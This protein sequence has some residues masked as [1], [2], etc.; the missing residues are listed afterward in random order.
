MT[1]APA[2]RSPTTRPRRSYV[3]IA[4]GSVAGLLGAFLFKDRPA[5]AGRQQPGL[6][7]RRSPHSP[8]AQLRTP[9]TDRRLDSVDDASARV[10]EVARRRPT[11]AAWP[12][13][14]HRR[15]HRSSERAEVGEPVRLR[16]IVLGRRQVGQ[17]SGRPSAGRAAAAHPARLAR[18]GG[19]GDRRQPTDLGCQCPSSPR[20]GGSFGPKRG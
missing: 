18:C 17:A 5:V 11:A 8:A 15:P 3:D 2:C 14:G 7:G 4:S 16:R 12:Y 6:S 10:L 9:S 1:S 20:R 13:R 19:G